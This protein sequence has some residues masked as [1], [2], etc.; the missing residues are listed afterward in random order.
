MDKENNEDGSVDLAGDEQEKE[1]G[2]NENKDG[3]DENKD[4]DT[5]NKDGDNEEEEDEVLLQTIPSVKYTYVDPKTSWRLPE[6]QKL[7]EKQPDEYPR[8][9]REI[10]VDPYKSNNNHH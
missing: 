8:K 6:Q 9:P 3:D 5:E 2:D 10:Y 4:G 7:E 1:D